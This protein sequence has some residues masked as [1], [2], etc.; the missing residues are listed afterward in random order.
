V[1]QFLGTGAFDLIVKAVEEAQPAEKCLLPDPDA[2]GFFQTDNQR[3]LS[4]THMAYLKIA[5]G[6]DRHCTYCII[7]S[8][9]GRQKSRPVAHILDEARNLITA[10]VKE[11]V[12]VAQES[13]A[14]GSDLG[15]RHG[16]AEL[17]TLL[18]DISPETWIRVLYGHPESIDPEA[19]TVMGSTPN[20]CAYF[21]IPVQHASDP[22]LKRMG[23]HYTGNDLYHLF[24][25]IRNKVPD[26]SLRTTLIVGFP[27]E[28]AAD[29]ETLVSF[30]DDIRF[31]HLGVFTYSDSEDLP[32]HRMG[33]HVSPEKAEERHDKIM[34]RQL[35]ISEANNQKYIDATL[36]VLIEEVSEKN[37][38]TGRTVFQAPEVDGLTFV[39]GRNLKPGAFATVK[40]TDAFEYDIVGEIHVP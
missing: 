40:I 5:E 23:R 14:Y 15:L 8:L 16:L 10:G 22:V 21:D 1:D 26:A 13:T 39:H 30:V 29:F 6:C 36:D 32:S 3:Y 2:I 34:T 24:Q 28:T 37:L 20:I 38:Y 12:L 17:L 9:R 31:D 18:A 4:Q 27:G 7:P 11:L 25:D 19:I 35:A 33:A